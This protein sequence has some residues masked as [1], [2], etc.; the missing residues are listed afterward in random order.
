MFFSN[1]DYGL[2]FIFKVCAEVDSFSKAS[3]ILR[4]KQPAISY[5]I[6]KL[7]D[8]LN[9]KLFERGNFGIHLT[10]AGSILYEYVRMADDSISS[11]ISI[12]Q[13]LNK[14]EITE[15]NVGVSLNL[16]LLSF[17]ESLKKFQTKFPN[18]KVI[19]R[20]KN[21]DIMFKDLQAKKL[22]VVIFNSSKN[23]NLSG[24]D[25]KKI[26]NNNIVCV[27]IPKY[28]KILNEKNYNDTII[29][30]IVPDSNTNLSKELETEHKNIKFVVKAISN[31]APVSKELLKSGIGIGYI[32]EE[33][34]RDEI[35]KGNL[36]VIS[37]KTTADIYSVDVAIQKKNNNFVINEFI[38]CL[39]GGLTENNE[40]NKMQ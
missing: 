40:K 32:N 11:G 14:K 33:I 18:V 23:M 5:S 25:I 2:L 29:P 1:L 12:I 34:V 31:S 37:S 27:G 3:Q 19:I 24:I 8:L 7:E 17:A 16:P 10:K 38:K 13:E 21:E 4:V 22:D 20:C 9:I 28:Q 26:K 39:K 36:C 35:E 6:S 30:I 15:I